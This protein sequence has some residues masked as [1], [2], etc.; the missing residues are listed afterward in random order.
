MQNELTDEFYFVKRFFADGRF[1]EEDHVM[2]LMGYEMQWTKDP[3]HGNAMA[4]YPYHMSDTIDSVWLEDRQ[5]RVAMY[6]IVREM[7]KLHRLGYMH[8]DIKPANIVVDVEEDHEGE[9]RSRKCKISII[10]W[11]LANTYF[12]GAEYTFRRGTRCTMAP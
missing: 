10:D 1:E 8:M 9:L 2:K 6:K 12:R 4:M 5:V 3:K 7:E 11:N